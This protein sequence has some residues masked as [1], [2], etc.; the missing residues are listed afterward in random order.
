MERQHFVVL[1]DPV[2]RGR[3][4]EHPSLR[5]ARRGWVGMCGKEREGGWGREARAKRL[6]GRPNER[7]EEGGY[8]RKKDVAKW[9]SDEEDGGGSGMEGIPGE[10]VETHIL[11]APTTS[12][13]SW[14][15]PPASTGAS[16]MWKARGPSGGRRTGGFIHFLVYFLEK[17]RAY[18][19]QCRARGSRDGGTGGRSGFFGNIRSLGLT[20]FGV[21][22]EIYILKRGFSLERE[23]FLLR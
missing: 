2:G 3:K 14:D 8:R 22:C 21:S 15:T 6:R 23:L 4:T 1:I 7:D 19:R 12:T 11:P 17:I 9:P 20:G 16:Y 5:A 13:T 18:F 10:R